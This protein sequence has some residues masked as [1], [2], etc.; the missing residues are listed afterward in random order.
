MNETELKDVSEQL[1]IGLLKNPLFAFLFIVGIGYIF[2]KFG[3][4]II[5]IIIIEI[6]RAKKKKK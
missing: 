5:K 1:T 3:I 6:K 4:P 2:F